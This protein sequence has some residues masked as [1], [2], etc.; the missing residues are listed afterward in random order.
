MVRWALSQG[1]TGGTWCWPDERR[2]FLLLDGVRVQELPRRL[3]E[4]SDG[5]LEAD[6]L[7]AGTPWAEVKEVSPWLVQLNGLNDP[8]LQAFLADGLEPEWGYL[9]ESGA[10]LTEVADHLRSLILVRH[11]LDVPMLL[12]LADP[13]VIAALLQE[14]STPALVPWGPIERLMLPDAVADAW[15]SWAPAEDEA[16]P[17]VPPPAG[18]RLSEAQLQRLQACD[19]RRHARQL[20]GFVDQHC[21]GWLTETSRSQRHA[22]L[23]EIVHEARGMGFVSPREWALLCSLMSRLGI[24]TWQGDESVAECLHALTDPQ[25]GSALARLEAALAATPPLPTT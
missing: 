1:L 11:P 22:Q 14:G 10:S 19:L 2:V 23:I 6:L 12:R 9:I 5:R 15:H 13:A 8:V 20:M 18:Y 4:W 16:P 21:A 17:L 24:T 25:R 7:Y 3:Y